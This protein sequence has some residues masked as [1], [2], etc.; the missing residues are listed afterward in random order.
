MLFARLF[1]YAYKKMSETQWLS[2]TFLVRVAT[3]ARSVK[4]HLGEPSGEVKP[5]TLSHRFAGF[6][7]NI[8]YAER[9]PCF[10]LFRFAHKS[11]NNDGYKFANSCD[12]KN[13]NL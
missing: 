11:R 2:P 4:W 12:G 1:R 8:G 3:R 13:A 10:A 7:R 9:F 6:H 5:M